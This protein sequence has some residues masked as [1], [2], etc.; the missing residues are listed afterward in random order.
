MTA[1]WP[2]RY[3]GPHDSPGFTLWRDFMAWQRGLN[4][5]LRP[6]GLTQ[7]QFA[8]LA[9]F[10]WLA[11]DG[12]E[13]TQQAVVDL[14][15]LDRMHVSQISKRLETDG[16]IRRLPAQSDQRAKPVAL[17][18]EGEALLARALPLVEEYDRACFDRL[19]PE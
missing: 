17:T 13:V 9:V 12:R 1:D 19:R 3:A 18:A 7:P 6:L 10:G 2:S 8:I 11:Q 16:L 4:A 15:G 14:V 5:V